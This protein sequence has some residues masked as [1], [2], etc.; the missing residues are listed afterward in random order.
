MLT[1][2]SLNSRLHYLFEGIISKRITVIIDRFD[3]N[4][5]ETTILVIYRLGRQKLNQKQSISKFSTT[6]YDYL[7][8]YDKQRI[9][10]F[11]TLQDLLNN[12]FL[13]ENSSKNNL[14]NY[15]KR[16]VKN[17]QLF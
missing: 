15:I 16:S 4:N 10:K 12:L 1:L 6:Y 17:D 5:D 7:S 11:S 14:T 2:T 8:G 13:D 3:F 9:T